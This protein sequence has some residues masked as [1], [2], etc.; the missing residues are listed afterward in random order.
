[1]KVAYQCVEGV[2]RFSITISD[3]SDVS[4]EAGKP[5]ATDNPAVIAELDAA[6]HAV[7]RVKTK[8]EDK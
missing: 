4:V 2:Q 5:F 6:P 8:E 7:S 3:G 1:M